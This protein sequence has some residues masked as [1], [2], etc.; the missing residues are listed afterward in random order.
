MTYILGQ[1]VGIFVTITVIIIQQLKKRTQI[2][3][4]S[5]F[6]N[7]LGALNVLLI[8]GFGAGVTVNFVAI[9]Q[10][11]IAL[12][13]EKKNTVETVI[14]KIIF[15]ILY[16]GVGIFT[17]NSKYDI[18]AI[19]AAVF[20]MVAM[21]QKKEQRIRLFLLANMGSWTIYH[22]I[23]RS[24][25]IFAQL[26]GIASAVIALIRYRKTD[27]KKRIFN[28][29]EGLPESFGEIFSVNLQKDKKTAI[30]LNG[31]ALAIA[32]VMAVP[33][34]FYI[35]ITDLFS[36]NGD[37]KLYII[38]MAVLFGGLVIYMILH[39]AVHGIGMKI[40]G[41][42]KVKFGFTGLYAFAGSKD[43]YDKKTYIFIALAP[44]IVWGAVL[45]VINA[46]VPK[47]W[48]WVVYFI[49]MSNI[50]GAAGDFYVTLRFMRFPKDILISD[51]GVG[52]T[53]Y[54]AEK[55]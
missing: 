16:V 41:T 43:Y 13:H 3:W 36:I 30:L 33:A 46:F 29:Y 28:S 53:V 1:I 35:P 8:D 12:W 26:A 48:F 18:L 5:V 38:K 25:G 37:I 52:M 49:Q 32:A 34:H 51:S 2:L 44:V 39:E 10:L 20:Y 7:I 9:L 19:L 24:T 14:E 21:M 15:L 55:E 54:S 31:A 40:S 45:A 42:K 6:V 23:L 22:G 27:G 11:L 50:S 4:A 17:Y 47:E